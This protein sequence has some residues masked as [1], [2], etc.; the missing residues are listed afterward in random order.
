MKSRRRTCSQQ[1][2]A[3]TSRFGARDFFR[4]VEAR[5]EPREEE[6]R[7][8]KFRSILGYSVSTTGGNPTTGPEWQHLMI[9]ESGVR[10]HLEIRMDDLK[11][12]N[13]DAIQISWID[14]D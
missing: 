3:A 6:S 10:L 4:F 12:Q 8:E 2:G 13:F 11:A 14:Y 5:E 7:E 1:T 9:I